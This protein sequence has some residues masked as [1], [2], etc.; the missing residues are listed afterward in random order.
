MA[1]L[2]SIAS[3]S[4]YCLSN[5]EDKHSKGRLR[6]GVNLTSNH[7]QDT[8]SNPQAQ[9]VQQS[10]N[11][12]RLQTSQVAAHQSSHTPALQNDSKTND[13]AS[14]DKFK[15]R[16]HYCKKHGHKEFECRRKSRD[17]SQAAPPFIASSKVVPSLEMYLDLSQA[18]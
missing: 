14:L 2:K 11:V 8:Q 6:R 3:S 7:G 12:N 18:C 15:G 1:T 5:N 9:Q 16:C 4:D 10:Y 13:K 17:L